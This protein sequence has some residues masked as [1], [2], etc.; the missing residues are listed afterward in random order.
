MQL[1]Y[2]RRVPDSPF[3]AKG[4]TTLYRGS[5]GRFGV[6][7]LET[8]DGHAFSLAHL[9]HPGAAAVVPFLAVDRILLLRQYRF[10]ADG[11]IWEIPAGKLDPAESPAD[12]AAREL[13]EETGYSAA[14]LEASGRILTAPGFTDECIHLFNAYNLSPG[15]PDREPSESIELHEVQF[16][17]AL[18]MVQRGE[19]IDAKSIVA[20]HHAARARS[21]QAAGS[22]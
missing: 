1:G 19:I 17:E 10:A 3:R 7:E 14:R 15:A 11:E 16:E 2:S 9:Q 21:R 4:E 20:L 12:C 6:H 22:E 18:E 8:P 5:I 13:R